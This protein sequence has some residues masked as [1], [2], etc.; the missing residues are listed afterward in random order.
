MHFGSRRHANTTHW[1]K[2]N[3][4]EVVYESDQL[5]ELINLLLLGRVEAIM[6]NSLLFE[7][8]LRRANI[9]IDHFQVTPN[10][11]KP[12]GVYFGRH[13]TK[14]YPDFIDEFNKHTHACR[15]ESSAVW[16]NSQ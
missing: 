10:I 11:S 3:G 4:F 14:Q 8:A 6:D 15:F 9:H 16:N 5:E 12:L 2:L 1:L 13:F 7:A